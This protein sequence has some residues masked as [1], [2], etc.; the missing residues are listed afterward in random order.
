MPLASFKKV[1]SRPGRGG[2][3]LIYGIPPFMET[4]LWIPLLQIGLLPAMI[5]F[6]I[7]AWKKGYWGWFGRFHYTLFV[8]AAIVW[9]YFAATY[10]LLGHRY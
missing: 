5:L 1:F 4:L 8:L 7:L 6:A 10:N 2:G 9:I 3:E